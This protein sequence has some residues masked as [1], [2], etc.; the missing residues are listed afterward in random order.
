MNLQCGKEKHQPQLL[1]NAILCDCYFWP[2]VVLL[3]KKKKHSIREDCVDIKHLAI[4]CIYV[5]MYVFM[6]Y[7]FF[8][9]R[10]GE[11]SLASSFIPDGPSCQSWLMSE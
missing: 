8:I 7:V 9:V 3:L 1:L 6:Y 4:D 11:L 2:L 10:E 5:F